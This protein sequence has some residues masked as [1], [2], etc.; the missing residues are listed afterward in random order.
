MS[1]QPSPQVKFAGSP[2][3]LLGKAPPALVV[4]SISVFFGPVQV[5]DGVSLAVWPGERVCVLGSNG[6][7]KSTT[8]KAIAGLVPLRSGA[9]YFDGAQLSG[10][11]ADRIVRKGITLVPQGRKVFYDQTVEENLLLGAYTRRDK[12][13]IRQDMEAVYERFPILGERRRQLAGS[14]SGGEQQMLAIGRALMSRPRFLMLDEPSLG[15]SPIAIDALFRGLDQLA[16][17]GMTM[18]IV[19]QLATHALR[20]AHRGYVLDQ[21]RVVAWGTVDELRSSGAVMEAYLGRAAAQ[22]QRR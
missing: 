14:L 20:I 6:S 12:Q 8:L 18:L 15:L 19:E 17:E 2:P 1:A 9:I 7:G 16:R 10:T 21:G 3:P 13:G 11:E 22:S 4:D 5:L